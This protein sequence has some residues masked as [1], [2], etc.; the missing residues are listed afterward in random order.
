MRVA[1]RVVLVCMTLA[2]AG[3]VETAGGPY[4]NPYYYG[5]PPPP[6]PGYYYGPGYG[7]DH[8]A[9]AAERD[10]NRRRQNCNVQWSNCVA[11]CNQF[12]NANQRAMCI[13]SCN[14]GLNQCMNSI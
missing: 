2:G 11:V 5:P 1:W 14:N 4:G 9:Q 13:A 8:G 10:R 7:G 6:P 12:T 3:C